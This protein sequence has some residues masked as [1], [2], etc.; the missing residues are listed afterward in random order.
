MCPWKHVHE[1]WIGI[2]IICNKQKKTEKILWTNKLSCKN[3][4]KTTTLHPNENSTIKDLF[5]KIL[6]YLF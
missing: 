1:L 5:H 6:E 2:V 3:L 4:K